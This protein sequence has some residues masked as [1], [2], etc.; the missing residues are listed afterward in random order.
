MDKHEVF[1]LLPK[2]K[3]KRKEI[4]DVRE[5]LMI[6]FVNKLDLA[7]LKKVEYY[8]EADKLLEIALI[9]IDKRII[10]LKAKIENT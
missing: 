7:D 9:Y 6:E 3:L 5:N 8:T 1:Q 4:D 10:Q 2:L